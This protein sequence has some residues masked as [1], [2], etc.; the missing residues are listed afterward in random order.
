MPQLVAKEQTAALDC[1]GAAY[2]QTIYS[3][4]AGPTSIGFAR[5]SIYRPFTGVVVRH[6][7]GRARHRR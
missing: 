6:G 5:G 7:R 4:E 1:R 2:L 3:D